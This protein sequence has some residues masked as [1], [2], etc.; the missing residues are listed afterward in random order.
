MP[1][2]TTPSRSFNGHAYPNST[3]G[4]ETGRAHEG[5]FDSDPSLTPDPFLGEPTPRTPSSFASQQQQQPGASRRSSTSKVPYGAGGR[6]S[7][8]HPRFILHTDAGAVAEQQEEDI[9]ELP[10]M[11]VDT[12][13][14]VSQQGA[15]ASGSSSKQKIPP[16]PPIP[17]DPSRPL[18]YNS[19][20]S[21]PRGPRTE[22]TMSFGAASTV[23]TGYDDPAFDQSVSQRARSSYAESSH[24]AMSSDGS[25]R[26]LRMHNP[27]EDDDEDEDRQPG[28]SSHPQYDF[29][30]D[31]YDRADGPDDSTDDVQLAYDSSSHDGPQ[32][33]LAPGPSPRPQPARTNS[34]RP[35]PPRQ[36]SPH[37]R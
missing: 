16:P 5:A 14:A 36:D 21:F 20:V 29:L 17:D 24:R 25:Q 27:D 2:P 9:V 13:S 34:L 32:H 37:A 6:P 31:V 23:A 22:R 8:G 11:Y 35:Q 26:P 3:S 19:A 15:G 28:G 10:P 18:S 7:L 4:G 1:S 33:P 12:R 30:D